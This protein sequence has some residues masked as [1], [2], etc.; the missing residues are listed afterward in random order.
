MSTETMQEKAHALFEYIKEVSLLNQQK[1]LDVDRQPGT[2]TLRSLD[3]PSCVTLSSRDAVDGEAA[4]CGDVLFS[5]HKPEFTA[6]PSPDESLT[7]WLASG[8]K[9][10]HNAAEYLE[11]IELQPEESPDAEN[12]QEEPDE[13]TDDTAIKAQ[14]EYF[15][16]DPA[17]AALFESWAQKRAV[18]VEGEK[19][20]ARL[21]SV[22]IDLFDMYNLCRQFPD[23]LEIVI[24]NGLLEDEQNRA[25][26]HPLF[27]KR[28]EL[29]LDSLS[30][31]LTLSDADA[32]AQIYLP[33]F[34]AMDDIN[35]DIVRSLEKKAEEENIHPWDH[36][37][38]AD[39]LK[40]VA[41]QLHAGSR[42]LDDGEEAMQTDERILVRWEPYIILR[43]R[44]DGTIRALESILENLDDG[45]AIP[46][47]LRGVL[48][49]FEQ[50]VREND[51]ECIGE[52]DAENIW[53]EPV[54][55]PLEDEDILL[56]KPANRE[57]M[58]IVR[59]IEHAPAVL[60]QGP[61]GTGKTHTI[62]NL[63]GHFL[64]KGKTVLVTSHTSKALTVLKE[65]VPKEIQALCVAVFGDNRADMEE[66]ISTII[67]RMSSPEFDSQKGRAEKIRA[68]RHQTLL[69]LQKARKLV[70][71]I[72]HKEFEPIVY[73][74]E[75]WSP[76]KA[77][78]YVA[79][80]E[81]LMALIPG[82]IARDAA[83]PLAQ[84]ELEWLY[85][86]NALLTGQ[87]EAELA[88][89]LPDA[90]SLI[91]PE[92]LAE[93]LD[94]LERMNLQLQMINAE[95]RS[96]LAWKANR[97][98]VID[99][100]SDLVFASQ[101]DSAAENVLRDMLAVYQSPIP[102][103]AVLAISD[104][105]EDALPRKRWEQLL[106]LIDETYTKAQSVLEKQLT[107]PIKLTA[108]SHEA[109]MAPYEE[110]RKDAEKHGRIKKTLFM[111][112]EKKNAL[113]SVTIDGNMPETLDDVRD[114]QAFFE[115]SAL[116]D[117]LAQLWDDLI[118]AHG[119]RR[120]AELGEEPERACYQQRKAIEF[121]L[122]WVNVSRI[123]LCE[124]AK[125]AGVGPALL[126]IMNGVSSFT[127]DSAVYML[128]YIREQLIPAVNLLHLVN[129]LCRIEHIA[130]STHERLFECSHSAVCERL[131]SA[132]DAESVDQYA[133]ELDNLNGIRSKSVIQ[134]RRSCLIE[135]V[136][137]SAPGWA[138]A[139]RNRAG[140]HAEASVPEDL[141]TAWKVRQLSMAV[142]E[143]TSTS[144]SEAEG[145]VTHC[146]KQFR[147]ET[148]KLAAALAWCN[149][150]KR[151]KEHPE[152]QQ[153]LNGW[154][155]T[156][157]KI[158]KGKGKNVP[159]L[160]AEARKLMI[161]CQKAVP[162]W[163]MP[164][165]GVMSSIDPAK[166]KFDV[167]IID[168][169]SQ[170]DITASAILYMGKKIIV[171]GDDEQVSPPV[172]RP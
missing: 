92:Q 89:D 43:K 172:C 155:Q 17:R 146:V 159:A 169:A 81:K 64:A 87:E 72:R 38:G 37:K 56:P 101:G 156:M 102:G 12:S 14:Y 144:L 61:P 77:A 86:S 84:E 136:A 53:A 62:A 63:L 171:V 158:G 80:H 131:Q 125:K 150:Q 6:C 108:S 49:N 142:D 148:E 97:Y 100:A 28:A 46:A 133:L 18:W 16:D 41:H 59:Q 51:D 29:S 153:A 45:A 8:W 151:I 22:F 7:K 93:Q 94:L 91:T 168:E 128:D 40:S 135:K 30:N 139:I 143:I 57:Q 73:C 114:I 79:Q 3:D 109:L 71:A 44:P 88:A 116:R 145:K 20:T 130:V 105:A 126:Q 141:L 104:G 106:A 107:R 5:F 111:S 137:V 27:L 122:N 112:R 132:L 15:S 95:R 96:H 19:H 32:P 52:R 58:Q 167:I 54:Q 117:R 10:Y 47:S 60:V 119:S 1:I 50:S 160:L 70:Y 123:A 69:E 13:E 55:L 11:K 67:E 147:A 90:E 34:S 2:I 48:G 152:M 76:S 23:T 110:L 21:R 161:E 35:A 82:E 120:F 98:A 66:S 36:H 68:E 75:S 121:W 140:I 170:S 154:R 165:S 115:L 83:F 127:D 166:T 4:Y 118:A 124:Q 138:D 134:A 85:A 162:A 129:E 39:F 149:L 24:G 78:E 31:T 103:W 42:Y 74:G 65:K 157:A 163:I 164:V 33:M 99:Q 113:D 25:I 26:R 9:D